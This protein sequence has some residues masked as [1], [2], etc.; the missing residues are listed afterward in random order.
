MAP[1]QHRLTS[2]AACALLALAS[3][4]AADPGA[5]LATCGA[6]GVC[7]AAE[8]EHPELDQSSLLQSKRDR[9]LEL[10]DSGARRGGE[11]E[12][13]MEALANVN[14]L[15]L[16]VVVGADGRISRKSWDEAFARLDVGGSG[17]IS[18]KDLCDE[19]TAPPKQPHNLTKVNHNITK[20]QI[21]AGVALFA[22]WFPEEAGRLVA[23]EPIIAALAF[24]GT[25]PPAGTPAPSDPLKGLVRSRKELRRRQAALMALNTTTHSVECVGAIVQV[26]GSVIGLLFSLIGLEAPSGSLLSD[27]VVGNSIV[28]DQVITIAQALNKAQEPFDAAYA[29]KDM[30]MVLYEEGI[31]SEAIQMSLAQLSWW[32]Y[33]IMGVQVAAIV[34]AWLGTGGVAF[35][36]NIALVVFDVKE[37]FEGALQIRDEC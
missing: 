19:E 37:L 13:T 3:V 15:D 35:V 7:A 23:H 5:G 1:R 31:F 11:D 10:V 14:L 4:R 24:N 17:S 30:F 6:G 16:Q 22:S 32:E 33:S 21:K 36:A 25:L 34:A 28:L 9:R 26:V 20:A 18:V 8:P 27:L 12:G 2:A 29:V